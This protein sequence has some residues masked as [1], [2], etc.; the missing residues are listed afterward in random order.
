MNEKLVKIR[1]PRQAHRRRADRNLAADQRVKHP[2][3]DHDALP[4]VQFDEGDLIRPPV[5]PQVLDHLLAEQR[6]PRVMNLNSS[7]GAF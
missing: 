6:M 7:V 1:Q 4:G 5:L 2:P 3:G